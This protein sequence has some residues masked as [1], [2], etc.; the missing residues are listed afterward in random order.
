MCARSGHRCSCRSRVTWSRHRQ[1]AH[2]GG[3]AKGGGPT[4][5]YRA[6]LHPMRG[7]DLARN[8]PA[9]FEQLNRIMHH[10][11]RYNGLGYPMGLTGH[12]IPEFA[13][14]LAI[15]DSFGQ[16]TQPRLPR[17]AI[18]AAEALAELQSAS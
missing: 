14:I 8:I 10:H 1:A 15:A 2:A 16:M 4:A 7:L 6:E 11:E 9:T 12:E 17:P 13:R 18:S 3:G 5:R